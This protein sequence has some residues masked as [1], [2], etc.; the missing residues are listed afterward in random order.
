MNRARRGGAREGGGPWR[1][2]SALAS[3]AVSAALLA[4]ALGAA[5]LVE[6]NREGPAQTEI[7]VEIPRGASVASIARRLQEAGVVRHA[8]AFEALARFMRLDRRMKA[9]EYALPPRASV[10]EAIDLIASGRSLLYAVTLPEGR[11]SAMAV[12]I[13][14]QADF[15]SGDVPP[16]PPEG[17]LLPETYKV[18]RGTERAALLAQ[19][20]EAHTRVIDSLWETRAAYLPFDTKEEAVILA[21]IVERE[22]GLAEERPRVAAVFVNRL[23]KGMR[24]E[25]DP[26]IIYGISQGRPLGRGIRRS[27]LDR[28]TPYN[29][30]QIDGLPPTPIANPGRHA[31]A[32]VLNPPQTEDLFF[33]AIDP[34]DYSAGHVFSKTYAEHSAAVARLREAERAARATEAGR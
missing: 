19:M 22:T 9:G 24:L 28:K 10:R 13:L 30:Y 1:I 33:V 4:L 6:T 26:T 7:V 15:L 12:D 5:F 16:V 21:S 29:T 2:A 32:A 18:P 23:R 8:L 14:A 25:S 3:L 31:I 34:M 11:T 27:E 17:A 20:M